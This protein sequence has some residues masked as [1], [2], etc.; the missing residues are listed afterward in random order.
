M[1]RLSLLFAVL[2]IVPLL[3]SNSP[4]EYDDR[5]EE[6]GIEGTWQLLAVERNGEKVNPITWVLALRGGKFT[7][8]DSD[9]DKVNGVYRFDTT[10]KPY[11]LDLIPEPGT[12]YVRSAEIAEIHGPTL[13]TAWTSS[14][15]ANRPSS[16]HDKDIYVGTF[17]RLK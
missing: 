4:K 9:G 1:R 5:T 2:L 8:A 3:G 10:Q 17:K 15:W 11:H 12:K 7:R 14:C 16:L 13:K 6:V